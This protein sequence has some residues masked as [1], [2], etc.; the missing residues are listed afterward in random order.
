MKWFSSDFHLG[1]H[2]IAGPSVSNWSG[3]YRDFESVH[4]M[5][6]TIIQ[7]INK[8]VAED[9]ELYFLGDFC[10]GGHKKTPYYRYQINCLN[11]YVCRGNHDKHIDKYSQCFVDIQD[12]MIVP[13]RDGITFL[14]D[15]YAH[16]VWEGSHKGTLHLFGHSHGS[17]PDYGRSMDVGIDVA[18]R[19]TGEYRPFSAEELVKRLQSRPIEF[20][21]HHTQSTNI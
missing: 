16:R 5:N 20:P 9:D 8:Y 21:D 6:K 15:H 12:R 17:L 3:G 13:Y 7:T 19:L 2:N 10:F 1:H 14:C 18:Y 4:E 11:I